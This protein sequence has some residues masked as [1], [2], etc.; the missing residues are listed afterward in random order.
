[1]QVLIMC[2][3]DLLKLKLR[4]IF[5]GGTCVQT[6][7]LCNGASGINEDSYRFKTFECNHNTFHAKYARESLSVF[8]E[9]H[10]KEFVH[11]IYHFQLTTQINSRKFSV[12]ICGQF[13]TYVYNENIQYTCNNIQ[14]RWGIRCAKIK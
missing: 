2:D 7:N 9:T 14:V 10:F 3:S 4:L 1:M 5:F 8:I 11:S 6:Q 12:K 13:S